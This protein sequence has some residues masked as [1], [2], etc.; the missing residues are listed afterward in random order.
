MIRLTAAEESSSTVSTEDALDHCFKAL[1]KSSQKAYMKLHDSE[2]TSFSRIKSI[3]FSNCY[4]LGKPDTGSAHGGS[5]IGLLASRINH[6]CIPNVQFSF[7]DTVPPQLAALV[8]SDDDK[9]NGSARGVML[10]YTLRNLSANRE[11]LSNYDS[12]F[13]TA[14][15]RQVKHQMYYG[16]RCDCEACTGES[17]F[18]AKSDERRRELAWLKGQID[19]AD[20]RWRNKQRTCDEHDGDITN[21]K[22]RDEMHY[23][24]S[25][26]KADALGSD[27]SPALTSSNEILSSIRPMLEKLEGLLIK[28]GLFG[29]DLANAYRDLAI[30]SARAGNSATAK[31][32]A[33]KEQKTCIIAFGGESRRVTEVAERITDG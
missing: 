4:D 25:K 28:E 19:A 9:F 24:H 11:L 29:V 17:E 16:F 1:P 23:L 8:A 10:F 14:A 2:K 20:K 5:A 18:W 31:A 6:S 15:Q 21:K 33:T 3:Y 22:S 13:A 26:N 27:R 30:W 32:W 7:A 12:I